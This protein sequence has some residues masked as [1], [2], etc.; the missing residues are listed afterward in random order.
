M[1]S[2]RP[3]LFLSIPAL[4]PSL[5]TTPPQ[6]ASTQTYLHLNFDQL[7]AQIRHAPAP[8][9][10]EAAH[11]NN[12]STMQQNG[13]ITSHNGYMQNNSGLDAFIHA[14]RE[15]GQYSGVFD[16]DKFHLSV[17]QQEVPRA[18][19]ALAPLLFSEDCPFDQWKVTDMARVKPQAR[20]SQGAQFTLYVKPDTADSR[21]TA[22]A[23]HSIRHFVERLES[24]MTEHNIQP[25]QHPD[26]DVRPCHWQ[27]TSYRNELRSD[28]EG[29][30]EQSIALRN[31]PFFRLMSE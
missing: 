24:V 13:F 11:A 27:F 20:V 29:S 19:N 12:Y 30:Y 21:F 16:G 9:F 28:R 7:K 31:E 6:K 3:N 10:R 22:N 14:N 8:H 2:I 4:P 5:S 26:S 18:F 25:G 23:L 17:K 1:P 15:Q